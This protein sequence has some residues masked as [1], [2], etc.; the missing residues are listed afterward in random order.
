MCENLDD[1]TIIAFVFS[2]TTNAE[3]AESR[4]EELNRQIEELTRQFRSEKRRNDKIIQEQSKQDEI[5]RTELQ[6][7]KLLNA[8]LPCDVNSYNVSVLKLI[9]FMPFSKYSL[10]FYTNSLCSTNQI[11]K[12]YSR[13]EI[14][15][16][17]A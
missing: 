12:I 8:S 17:R 9:F 7:P 6:K 4:C 1:F 2:L 15:L 3:T 16:V 13:S 14:H 10:L 11:R 5:K